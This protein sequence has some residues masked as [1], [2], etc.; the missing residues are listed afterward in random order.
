M[1]KLRIGV[2]SPSPHALVVTALIEAAEGLALFVPIEPQTRGSTDYGLDNFR[3]GD[4]S[5]VVKQAPTYGPAK[6]G[7]GGKTRRYPNY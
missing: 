2:F 7:R 4:C 1:N 6:K 5:G 3:L